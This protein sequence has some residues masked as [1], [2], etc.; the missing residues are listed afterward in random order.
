MN[1]FTVMKECRMTRVLRSVDVVKCAA[2][3]YE[4]AVI[5]AACAAVGLPDGYVRTLAACLVC[6]YVIG[7]ACNSIRDW[8]AL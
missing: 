1:R 2:I 5:L 6:G 4:V 3:G 7:S 8:R